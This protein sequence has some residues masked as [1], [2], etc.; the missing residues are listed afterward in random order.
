[1]SSAQ[2]LKRVF[3]IDITVCEACEKTNVK[4][5]TCITVPA[6]IHK[7]LA[8]LDK[9]TLLEAKN[10]SLM[11]PLRASPA[12]ASFSDYIIQRDFDFGA[13]S[14]K[15]DHHLNIQYVEV[16][17]FTYLIANFSTK[18]QFHCLFWRQ[19]LHWLLKATHLTHVQIA[20]N[21][22]DTVDST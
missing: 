3:N 6:V 16:K 1:M 12:T 11:P 15:T 14:T 22:A 8:H 5:I 7:I 13:W 18:D 2:R 20:L 17:A 9:K 21:T 10:D 4:I 19:L